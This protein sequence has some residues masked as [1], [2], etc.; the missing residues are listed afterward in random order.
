MN[1]FDVI[2]QLDAEDADAA[3]VFVDGAI[4][5]RP[6]QFLLDT[7]AARSCVR[8]DDY[9]AT[10]TSVGTDTSS[11]VFAGGSRDLVS[12][13]SLT[14]GTINRSDFTLVRSAEGDTGRQNLIGMDLLKDLRCHFRFDERRVVVDAEDAGEDDTQFEELYVGQRGHPYV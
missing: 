6:Y 8:Y 12:A 9:T 11:G 14:L 4:G 10:F 1:G 2:I 13:P 7:G 5:G 3:E